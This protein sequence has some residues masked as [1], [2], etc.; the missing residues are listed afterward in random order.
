LGKVHGVNLINI[1]NG[2]HNMSLLVPFYGFTR[3]SFALSMHAQL[4]MAPEEWRIELSM[5]PE[6]WRIELSMTPEEWRR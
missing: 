6:E 2:R 4:S 5:P 1:L 3:I